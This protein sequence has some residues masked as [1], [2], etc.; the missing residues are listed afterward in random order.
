M[1][2]PYCKRVLKKGHITGQSILRIIPDNG[3]QKA[4]RRSSDEFREDEYRATNLPGYPLDIGYVGMAPWIS[5]FYCTNCKKAYAQMDMMM[6]EEED[7]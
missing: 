2:C 6:V 4:S 3:Q 1:N 5:A 7:A